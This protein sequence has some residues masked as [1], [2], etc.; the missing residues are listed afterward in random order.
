MVDVVTQAADT[1]V[2]LFS[3]RVAADADR[4]ALH[5][6]RGGQFV[7]TTWGEL[8]R[9]ARRTAAALIN[10]GVEPGDRVISVSENRYEWVVCDLAIQLARAVHTPV[11]APLSGPQIAFQVKDSG[12]RVVLLSG[13]HQAEKL[14]GAAEGLSRRMQYL[15]FDPCDVSIGASPVRALAAETAAIDDAQAAEVEQQAIDFVTPVS[16]ATILY[17]SGT[18]GEP[19]GVM[20]NQSHL[21]TNAVATLEAFCQYDSDLRLCFLPLSHIF[22]RTCDLYMWIASGSQLALAESR[23]TVIADCA[24]IKPTLLNGVPYF[25]DRVMRTVI[26]LGKADEKDAL[27]QIFG[28]RIRFFGSGGAALPIHVYDF[29]HERGMPILQGYG[30]TE[31]SPVITASSETHNRRGASG[32]PIADVEVK[33][34]ADG[35]VMTRGP[36]VMIGYYKN[37][38]ATDEVLRDGWFSTGDLGRL[39]EDGFLY[40]TGRKKELIVT[41][42][43]KNIAPVMLE[44]LLTQDPLIEQALVIGDDRKFLTALI[45][46]NYE[47]LRAAAADE[48]IDIEADPQWLSDP[49]IV[50]LVQQRV[51][52]RL[53]CVSKYEQAPKITLLDRPFSIERG[54]MTA[55]LSL[56]REIIAQHFAEQIEAM[57]GG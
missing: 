15:S 55:K 20:L 56:R 21:F 17:T 39:D 44:S 3:R 29:Y 53:A 22:A 27:R 26:E 6:K 16:L 54:E 24:A 52:E 30:L 48:D 47:A 49:Q 45:V 40:I 10:L 41:A 46:P 42:G 14:A 18:T 32:R 31:T 28:G 9:D 35:E 36:H 13:P 5:V 1:I 11:H 25:F 33:I 12:A 19:K 43:G 7:A 37:R 2:F 34:A 8:A 4:P 51:D 38:D 23:D 57:Y 50:H